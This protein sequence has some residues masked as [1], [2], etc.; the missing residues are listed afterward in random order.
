[1]GE[2]IIILIIALLFLGPDK[3]PEAAKTISEGIRGFRK[4]TKELQR[5]IEDDTE[6]GDA[7]RDI[8]SA[9][10]GDEL[11]PTRRPPPQI[12]SQ[13]NAGA[14]AAAAAG[15][16]GTLQA[17]D[18]QSTSGEAPAANPAPDSAGPASAASGQATDATA[19][20][21]TEATASAALTA[22][23]MASMMPR[24]QTPSG[25]VATGGAWD[26]AFAA[27]IS[28]AQASMGAAAAKAPEPS[29]D[30]KPGNPEPPV[31][32]GNPGSDAS[33]TTG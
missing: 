10:R 17:G 33:K 11:N 16:A 26:R 21:G 15:A 14:A 12:A 7:I 25:T 20:A 2:V 22:P 1:M 32:A 18:S 6:I 9:L 29:T 24:I 4:Q 27:H 31:T 13:Q 8:K 30:G 28:S 5:T 19:S 23:S 3:L